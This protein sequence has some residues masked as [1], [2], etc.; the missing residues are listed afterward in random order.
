VNGARYGSSRMLAPIF[1]TNQS[2]DS[3][4]HKQIVKVLTDPAAILHFV[5]Q[6]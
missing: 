2:L 5:P 3:I 4:G 6:A 1:V